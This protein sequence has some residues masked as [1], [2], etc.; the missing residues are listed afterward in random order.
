MKAL[1]VAATLLTMP[2]ICAA[3]EAWRDEPW[4]AAAIENVMEYDRVRRAEWAQ[5]ISLWLYVY[6][7]DVA[8][9]VVT[10]GIICWNLRSAGKP[11]DTWVT[12]TW[13]D[14]GAAMRGEFEQIAVADCD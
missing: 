8:W 12:V 14:Y 7:A 3:E 9:G 5:S 2:T 4:R 10:D 1:F 13:L 11:D 6:P